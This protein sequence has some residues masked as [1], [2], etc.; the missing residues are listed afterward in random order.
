[1]LVRPANLCMKDEDPRMGGKEKRVKLKG[2]KEEGRR[3]R[4]RVISLY[5]LNLSK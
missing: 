2:Q 4:S 3:R 1:M 5:Y